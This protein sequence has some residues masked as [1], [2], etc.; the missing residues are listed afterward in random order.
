MTDNVSLKKADIDDLLFVFELRNKP[1]IRE[2]A[3]DNRLI[4]FEEHQLW[5]VNKLKDKHS[6]MLIIQ[7][8]KESVGIIR[9]DLDELDRSADIT[10]FLDECCCGKSIG[11]VAIRESM[12]LLKA[13]FKSI[14]TIR[15][16]I[17][18]QNDGSRRFFN[19][20][21]FLESNT[22]IYVKSLNERLD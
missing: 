11:S 18:E 14:Q 9:Y 21:G 22:G 15:A 7:Y 8:Q 13:S 10:I 2:R 5:F 12:K 20:F 3:G 19:R 1:F 6:L 17:I 16:H 4:S